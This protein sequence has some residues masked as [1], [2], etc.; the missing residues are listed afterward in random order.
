MKGVLPRCS[1]SFPWEEKW[2]RAL[3]E[4]GWAARV[5]ALIGQG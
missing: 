4:S 5:T 2:L 1:H 3:P